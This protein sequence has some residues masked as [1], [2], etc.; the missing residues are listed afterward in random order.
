MCL[1][2]GKK[3]CLVLKK[4]KNGINKSFDLFLILGFWRFV[5][6]FRRTAISAGKPRHFRS[7]S[8]SIISP[9]NVLR[10][11]QKRCNLSR[12]SWV[13]PLSSVSWWTPFPGG[14]MPEHL[15]VVRAETAL[16]RALPSHLSC[17]LRL[18]DEHSP[19]IFTILLLWSLNLACSD[20]QRL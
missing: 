18:L 2:W 14:Q 4:S 15:C 10:F 16:L 7:H 3:V 13:L 20:T 11:S 6:G 19:L 12:L 5:V 9:G 17:S 1:I 8:T